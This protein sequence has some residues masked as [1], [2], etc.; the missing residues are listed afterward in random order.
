MKLYEDIYHPRPLLNQEGRKNAQIFPL[1]DKE[2][3]RGW[4]RI[5]NFG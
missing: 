4:L 1:L 2:G 5:A 3:V